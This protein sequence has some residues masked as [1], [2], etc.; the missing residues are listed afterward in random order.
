[1]SRQSFLMKRALESSSSSSSDEDDD[2]LFFVTHVAMT[3][4]ESDDETKHR[5]SIH[6]HKV[7]RRDRQEGHDRLFKDY[8]SDNPTYGPNYFRC[9]YVH[10][11][12]YRL[13]FN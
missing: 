13:K 10:N 4:N 6:G 7:L 3:E 8:F 1:M 12:L 2:F 5:G 11:N 9:R